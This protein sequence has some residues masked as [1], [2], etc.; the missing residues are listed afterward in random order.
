MHPRSRTAWSEKHGKNTT[1][2]QCFHTDNPPTERSP[3][4]SVQGRKRARRHPRS[5]TAWSGKCKKDT[6]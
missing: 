4:R 1:G 2:P 5:S 6:A 3:A